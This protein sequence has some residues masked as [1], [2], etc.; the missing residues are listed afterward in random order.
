MVRLISRQRGGLAALI[1][2]KLF[3]IDDFPPAKDSGKVLVIIIYCYLII[4]IT[5][6]LLLFFAIT[7]RSTIDTIQSRAIYYLDYSQ[8]KLFIYIYLHS[9]CLNYSGIPISRILSFSNHPITRTKSCFP[10]LVQHCNFTPD[11]SNSPIF[12]ANFRFL[13]RFVKSGFHCI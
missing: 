13:W 11:F 1:L 3:G 4:I 12:R 9:N 10:S 7:Q 8:Y 5:L 2:T 6:L